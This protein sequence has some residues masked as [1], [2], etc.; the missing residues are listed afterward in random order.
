MILFAIIQNVRYRYPATNAH[1]H[2]SIVSQK[3][4]GIMSAST[5]IVKAKPIVKICLVNDFTSIG[6]GLYVDFSHKLNMRG[7]DFRVYANKGYWPSSLDSKI[8]SSVVDA[9]LTPDNGIESIDVRTFSLHINSNSTTDVEEVMKQIEY[10]VARAG[11]SVKIL[12][13]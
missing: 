7:T 10:A 12:T 8:L 11:Y 6:S 2:Q 4:A 3:G 1:I 13:K 5:E 9:I